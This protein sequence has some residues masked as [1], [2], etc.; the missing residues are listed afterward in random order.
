MVPRKG[1]GDDG[2]LAL[3]S[4]RIFDRS[5]IAVYQSSVPQ[6]TVTGARSL[7]PLTYTF[8]PG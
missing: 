3:K 6:A 1:L 8:G 7:P 5:V 4:L 2:N